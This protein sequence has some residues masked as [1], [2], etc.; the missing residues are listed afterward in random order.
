MITNAVR[1]REFFEKARLLGHDLSAIEHG[2][3]CCTYFT[4]PTVLD[5]RR[6]LSNA[7][8]ASRRERQK[9]F[10][11]PVIAARRRLGQGMHDR[12]EAATFADGPI[13]ESD[14][15]GQ[16]RHLPV[17]VKAISVWEKT[18]A[19]GDVWDVS[20]RGSAWGIDD[21]EELYVTLNVGRLIIEPGAALIVRGNVFSLLCQELVHQESAEEGAFQ[22]GIL[23]T[24]FSVDFGYGSLHGTHGT[25]GAAGRDGFAGRTLEVERT[26]LG[27]RLR[28]EAD[29]SVMNGGAGEDGKDGTDGARGRNGGMCKLAELTLR[30]VTGSLTV[31]AQAGDGGHGG[32]G[33]HGG[34]G[35]CGGDAG[36]GHKLW[37]SIISGGDGGDGGRGGEG[38]A[39]GHAGNGGLASNIYIEVPVEDEHKITRVALPSSGGDGGAG[40]RGGAGGAGGIQGHGPTEEFDG[41]PGK[42]G[43]TGTRGRSGR[44]GRSRPAPWMFLNDKMDNGDFATRTPESLAVSQSMY[45][46][47][48]IVKGDY[49][50]KDISRTCCQDGTWR[51]ED[52]AG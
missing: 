40:G 20:V 18:I 12:G 30:S 7:T 24:P 25:D 32:Y 51:P 42:P 46:E 19:G 1:Q 52:V 8:E 45:M 38:G 14:V 27:F 13:E 33:G 39:G 6:V 15:A 9:T 21:M 50:A 37:R 36:N 48:L 43:E 23:P 11:N 2:E 17:R 35:G 16:N 49:D 22:I 34:N 41:R 3:E 26:L 10:F 5:G 29:L 44:H 28:E 4:L 31:F 47:Q